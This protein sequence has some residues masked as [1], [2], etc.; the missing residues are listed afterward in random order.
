MTTVFREFYPRLLFFAQSLIH[1]QTESEDLA[2]KALSTL[3]EHATVQR[4]AVDNLQSWL[5]AIVRNGCYDFLRH[6]RMKARKAP[7]L[8]PE[9]WWEEIE[10]RLVAADLVEKIYQQIQHL[11]ER[12]RQV[13]VLTYING[14]ETGEIAQRL[15][16]TESTVR[17]Q[18]ARAK[19][20]LKTALLR[21]LFFL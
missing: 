16:I 14:L 10:A 18:K 7:D 13:A 5:F 1:H 21:V 8:Q 9:E 20:L 6:E 4:E 3:W 19:E 2:M 11:P 17:S 15:A 12:C